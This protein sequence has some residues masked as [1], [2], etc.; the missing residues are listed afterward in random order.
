MK[1][2]LCLP[3]LRFTNILTFIVSI[4]AYAFGSIQN[5]FIRVL[6]LLNLQIKTKTSNL[7]TLWHQSIKLFC[8]NM[9]FMTGIGISS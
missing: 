1:W 9:F 7:K 4:I 2:H 5:N 3:T 6:A 8:Y